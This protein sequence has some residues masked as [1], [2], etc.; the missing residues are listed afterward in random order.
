LI[1]LPCRPN[2]VHCQL[3]R[4]VYHVVLPEFTACFLEDNMVDQKTGS[5]LM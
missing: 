1:L 2:R 5:E 4:T 3:V